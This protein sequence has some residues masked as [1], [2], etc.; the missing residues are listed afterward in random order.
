MA[1]ARVQDRVYKTENAEATTVTYG[2]TPT[3]GNLLVAISRGTD[4]P[5]ANASIAGWTLAVGVAV[6]SGSTGLGLWYKVA[7][8]SE[9]DDVVITWTGA[10]NI[11][12]TI[13]EYGGFVGT[14]ILDK[15][16]SV[17]DTGSIVTSRSSGT[18]AETSLADELCLAS[19]GMGDVVTDC[20]LTNSFV[21]VDPLW[22][23]S[24]SQ[25]YF[26]GSRVVS[27]T[28]AYETTISWTTA[29]KTGGLVATFMGLTGTVRRYTG[30]AWAK[31]K[32]MVRVGAAWEA[33]PVKRWTG[34]AW[35]DVDGIGG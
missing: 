9:P 6:I 12:I 20:S 21:T 27:S 14:P 17:A 5:V 35:V 3:E 19:F 4:S 28:G 22:S 34:S 18:T 29:R 24:A 31:A 11:Q 25:N 10:T 16:E 1:I 7:G 23:L 30:T 33:R 2:S 8:A 13:L 32:V 15:T 26:A